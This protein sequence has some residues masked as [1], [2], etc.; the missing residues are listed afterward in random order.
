LDPRPRAPVQGRGRVPRARDNIVRRMKGVDP[1]GK[2]ALF[3]AP[4]AA[5]PEQLRA[6]KSRVGRS[7]LF[8]AGPPEPGTVV[9]TCSRCISRARVGLGD[10]GI[11]ILTGSLLLPGRKR[12]WLLRCPAC[13]HRTW[14]SV[15]FRD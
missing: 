13:D 11:R 9:I 7:A 1:E 3:E 10:L 4:I 2:R 15:G 14:C 6:G 8:S 12:D 5:P